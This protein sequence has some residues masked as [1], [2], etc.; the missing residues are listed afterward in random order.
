[1]QGVVINMDVGTDDDYP[2]TIAVSP[3]I[4]WTDELA[5]EVIAGVLV[6]VADAA[7]DAISPVAFQMAI[8]KALSGAGS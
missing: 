7:G 1:M 8:M 2:A 4:E 3:D 5:G 6:S